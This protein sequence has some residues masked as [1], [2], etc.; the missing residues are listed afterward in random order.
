MFE[1]HSANLGQHRDDLL[2]GASSDFDNMDDFLDDDHKTP[3][4]V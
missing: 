2:E 3:N 1:N 4:R